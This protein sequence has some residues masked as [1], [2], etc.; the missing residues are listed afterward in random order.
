MGARRRVAGG[1]RAEGVERG[2]RVAIRLPNGLDW[3]LAFWGAQLA[4]AVAVPV[5]T[6]F[7][8]SEAQYVIDDSGAAYVFG[9][10]P[11]GEPLAVDDLEPDDLSA[12]FYTSGTTGFPK[13]AM[14][15]HANFLS[16]TENAS[17]AS[18]SIARPRGPTGDAHQRPA[19]P[20]HRLQQPAASCCSSSA[21][22]SYV[23]TNPLDLDGFLRTVSEEGVDMLTSVPA[24]YHA[25]TRHP[26][27]RRGRPRRR[28]RASPTAGRRSPR[29]RARR[30]WTRFPGA[31]WA[32]ASA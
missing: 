11:D 17:A 22:A 15:S 14:T 31:R 5:N 19:V 6:R 29:R 12:I 27:V 25:L 16:N 3:V 30:S 23:L 24:I 26:A 13:G 18:G 1:L 8:E 2:D 10:L 9:A 21:A 28:A 32:T 7:K 20:R 4:G